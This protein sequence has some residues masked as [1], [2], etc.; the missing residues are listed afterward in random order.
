MR[1]LIHEE[2]GNSTKWAEELAALNGQKEDLVIKPQK[3]MEP[4]ILDAFE[5]MERCRI[6]GDNPGYAEKLYVFRTLH[7]KKRKFDSTFYQKQEVVRKKLKEITTPYILSFCEDLQK[8]IS[9]ISKKFDFEILSKK[10]NHSKEGEAFIYSIKHNA[11][12]IKKSTDDLLA[13]INKIRL[14]DCESILKIKEIFDF[15]LEVTPE[16]FPLDSTIETDRITKDDFASLKGR[17]GGEFD[18]DYAN[19][20]VSYNTPSPLGEQF[21]KRP[22]LERYFGIK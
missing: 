3:E 17:I 11:D 5:S 10:P 12:A 6:L 19:H 13:A 2:V 20:F 14:M 8:E 7:E 4:E 22:M 21:G 1:R 15:V 18:S 16:E 9:R